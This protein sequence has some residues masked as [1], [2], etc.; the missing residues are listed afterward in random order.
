[1]TLQVPNLKSI[2][3]NV[4]KRSCACQP[5]NYKEK[6]LKAVR[7]WHTYQFEKTVAG[8]YIRMFELQFM[9][10]KLESFTASL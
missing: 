9:P 8:K 7:N 2:D 10:N 1:M 5:V 6:G 4:N 3:L